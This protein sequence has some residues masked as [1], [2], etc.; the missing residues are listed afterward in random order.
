[1][2]PRKAMSLRRLYNKSSIPTAEY[3][4]RTSKRLIISLEARLG[5]GS[6]DLSRGIQV[7]I[8]SWLY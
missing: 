5:F 2:F 7:F 8:E 4:D 1:M 6:V 3:D